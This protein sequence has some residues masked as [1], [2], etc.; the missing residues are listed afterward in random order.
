MRDIPAKVLIVDPDPATRQALAQ[1]L[2][3]IEVVLEI[4]QSGSLKDAS[5]TL[6][7][8]DANVLYLDPIALDLEAASKFI[9]GLRRATPSIVFVLYYDFNQEPR[10]QNAFGGEH[11]FQHYFKL[12]KR[13][14]ARDF[15]RQVQGTVDLCQMDLRANLTSD[16]V[17]A[18]QAALQKAKATAHENSATVP[19]AIL[20]GIQEQLAA[21][22]AETKS[23][24]HASSAAAFLGVALAPV[25]G[26]CFII[27]PYSQKW[28]AGVETIINECCASA[29]LTMTI[30]KTMDGRFVPHDIW[31]GIT[32]A[33]AIIA[34]LTGANANVAYEVGL[35]DA[36]GREVVL[37]CQNTEV[38]FDFLGQRL[39]VYEDSVQGA[40]ELRKRLQKRL[41]EVG[42]QNSS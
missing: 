7:D 27:M 4:R 32:G 42:R 17:A 23:K 16:E 22:A 25:R 19:L 13:T 35:A 34:D 41:L 15:N 28:S 9:V 11:R 20:Q 24:I 2:R 33:S 10:T 30:A 12:D 5:E 6:S 14:L 36:I 21:F 3:G 31:K 40:L 26:Q 8:Y 29:G 1:S 39:I 18:L 37:I 38:P